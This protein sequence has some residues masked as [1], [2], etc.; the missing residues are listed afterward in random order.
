MSEYSYIH[1]RNI[2]LI[3]SAMQP[4]IKIR[5]WNI[6]TFERL[7]RTLNRSLDGEIAEGEKII[8]I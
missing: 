1:K 8:R 5:F 7:N 6:E 4:P 3:F 2:D